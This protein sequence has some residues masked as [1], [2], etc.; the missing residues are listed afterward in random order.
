PFLSDHVGKNIAFNGSVKAGGLLPEGF[1]EG[2]MLTGRS[3][4]G[5]ISYQF[6]ESHGI[7]IAAAKPLPLQVVT[8]ARL[9]LDGD[10]QNVGDWGEAGDRLMKLYR[11]RM[12]VLLALGLTPPVAHLRRLG[13][14]S[15]EPAL[16]LTPELRSYEQEVQSILDSILTRNGCEL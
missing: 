14:G 2:D 10:R 6:L 12:I 16:E 1:I 7:T 5:M 13:D 4:A 9:V 8:T 15:I 3:H 11:H